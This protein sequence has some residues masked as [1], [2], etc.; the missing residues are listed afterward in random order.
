MAAVAF[1]RLDTLPMNRGLACLSRLFPHAVRLRA[2]PYV[3][4][5]VVQILQSRDDLL[6]A[7]I[8]GTER[9]AAMFQRID[10][11]LLFSCTCPF[12]TDGQSAC[13]HLWAL[14]L[15]AGQRPLIA[16]AASCSRFEATQ[17]VRLKLAAATPVGPI[18]AP[19][20]E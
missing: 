4:T 5:G 1:N 18:M 17:G 20:A 15:E 9:Y 8:A 11:A 2:V 7:N 19:D 16:E 13:K 6:F 14:A 3:G 10:D 12:F